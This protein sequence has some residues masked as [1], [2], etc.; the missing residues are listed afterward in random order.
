MDF[1]F[2]GNAGDYFGIWFVNGLLSSL[3][4]GIYGPWAKVKRLQYF[5]SHT[6]VDDSSF[7]F[8]ANPA[9]MLVSRLI[10]LGL[11]MLF[12]FSE[13]YSGALLLATVIYVTLV[14]LYLIA[15]PIVLTLVA[16]FRLRNSAWRNVRFDFNKDY[17]WAYRVYLAP[18][19]VLGILI[20]SLA[21]PFYMA[22][23]ARSDFIQS[24]A[25]EGGDS[26]I[27]DA[28]SGD[29]KVD[30]SEG[31]ESDIFDFMEPN[32]LIPA[33]VIAVLFVVLIP[34][35]DFIHT[36]FLA[37]NARFGRSK[38][39][40][41]STAKDFYAVYLIAIAFLSV[42]A[43]VW[44]AYLYFDIDGS[45]Y[46]LLIMLLTT[47]FF[48]LVKSYFKAQRY[49]LIFNN[50]M[51]DDAHEVRAKAKTLPVFWLIFTNTLAIIFTFGLMKPWA[52]IRIARYFLGVTQLKVVGSLNGFTASAQKDENAFAEELSDV[53]DLELG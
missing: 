32:H 13:P 4:F 49:N 20:I 41:T 5:Y 26:S 35:F 33:A 44:V 31:E 53:F 22:D 24:Q 16:S 17:R 42:L 15:A 52:E 46:F 14:V 25:V 7:Q 29:A 37:M 38:F 27:S 43:S 21:V 48:S 8:L 45:L 36:R 39:T 51:L 50:L 47:A 1:K 23:T 6:S 19:A 10:A 30:E 12:V 28:D 3:T 9:N 40:L 34:Y 2:T 18:L 11:F